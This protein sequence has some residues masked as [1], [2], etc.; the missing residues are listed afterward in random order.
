MENSHK[1]NPTQPVP[2]TPPVPPP[3]KEPAVQPQGPDVE[4]NPGKIGNNTEVD[5]D[6]TKIKTYPEKSSP[7]EK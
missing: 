3:R 1:L 2:G 7:E 5:L 4:I 6:T